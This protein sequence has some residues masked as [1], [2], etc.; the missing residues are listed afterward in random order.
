MWVTGVFERCKCQIKFVIKRENF[1][2][3]SFSCD[4]HQPL[5][6]ESEARGRSK[7]KLESAT[8]HTS[9]KSSVPL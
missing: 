9:Q 7:T 6:H 5:P 1:I 2:Y 3:L 4:Y 8:D